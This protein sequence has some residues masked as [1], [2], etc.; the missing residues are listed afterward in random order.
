MT[1]GEQSLVH[2]APAVRVQHSRLQ[3]GYAS[4]ER[5]DSSLAW[6]DFASIQGFGRLKETKSET[7]WD[8][9]PCLPEFCV[10]VFDAVQF[11]HIRPCPSVC[12]YSSETQIYVILIIVVNKLGLFGTDQIWVSSRDD[13]EFKCLQ[14]FLN[15]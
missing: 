12:L 10:S 4:S 11:A 14:G 7:S 9:R 3:C 8:L 13:K 2:R 5:N 15:S 6:W 1:T